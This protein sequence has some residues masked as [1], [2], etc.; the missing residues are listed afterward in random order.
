MLNKETICSFIPGH[1]C[2][3]SLLLDTYRIWRRWP[4]RPPLIRGK[5]ILFYWAFTNSCP[6]S[7][8]FWKDWEE[9]GHRI[10]YYT[11]PFTLGWCTGEHMSTWTEKR[12]KRAVYN[13]PRKY[14]QSY[15]ED[16]IVVWI[17]VWEQAVQMC[18]VCSVLCTLLSNISN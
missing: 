10:F 4:F 9:K 6:I 17:S 12:L 11:F 5:L 7:N 14:S 8:I 18:V 15:P 2:A 3:L 13:F 1:Y 16:S